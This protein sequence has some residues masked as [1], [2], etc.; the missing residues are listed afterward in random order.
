MVRVGVWGMPSFVSRGLA[1]CVGVS[2]GPGASWWGV[3]LVG[4][5]CVGAADA[6]ADADADAG[7]E[8]PAPAQVSSS[9]RTTS[10]SCSASARRSWAAPSVSGRSA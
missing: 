7:A 5:A 2:C 1:L 6:D 8:G 4:V 3:A 9:S 10:R